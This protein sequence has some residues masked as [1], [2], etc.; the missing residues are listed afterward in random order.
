VMD[1]GELSR[2]D[3][4]YEVDEDMDGV[5]DYRFG[6]PDFNFR[7]WNSNLVAR[8]EFSPGSLIYLVWSQGRVDF[9]SDGRFSARNG[10]DDLFRQ[11]PHDIFLI[12]VSRWFSL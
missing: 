8:W 1:D 10:I 5:A 6:N 3:G 2:T 9:T 11:H 12:K 7:E 4:G